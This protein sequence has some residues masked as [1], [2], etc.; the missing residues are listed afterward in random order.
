[1]CTIIF[2]IFAQ[3]K[4]FLYLNHNYMAYYEIRKKNS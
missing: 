4:V 3:S 2:L 1:M